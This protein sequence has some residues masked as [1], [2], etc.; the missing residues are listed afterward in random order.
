MLRTVTPWYLLNTQLVIHGE[1]SGLSCD[2]A[3]TVF[4]EI[5]SVYPG[6]N[7][8][9]SYRLLRILHL[10][11]PH[12]TLQGCFFIANTRF[13]FIA[14]QRHYIIQSQLQLPTSNE[15]L[16][17]LNSIWISFFSGPHQKWVSVILVHYGNHLLLAITWL[18]PDILLIRWRSAQCE[19][20][21]TVIISFPL[22]FRKEN[23][24]ALF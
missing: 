4:V 10:A 12:L 14:T 23:V 15:T 24:I 17:K 13:L 11:L 5:S 9:L 19:Q 20:W 2:Q 21:C 16:I 1:V 8:L 7:F 3:R 18:A 22:M 6:E